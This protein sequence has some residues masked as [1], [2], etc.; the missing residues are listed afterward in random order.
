MTV[1][2]AL[3]VPRMP[4]PLLCPDASEGYRALA[5][6]YAEAR[7]RIEAVQPDLI[8]LYSA[9]W[10]SILGHQVQADPAPEWVHVDQDFHALGSIPYKLR[11][12]PGFADAMTEAGQARGL[13]VRTVSY[14]GFPIDT[15]T[16]TALKLLNPDNRFPASVVSCNIY[17][18]RAET[19]VLGK[20]A[21]DAIR[22]QNRRVVAIA[23]T[24]ISHRLHSV[25]VPPDQD[26]FA[27]L[28][29]DEWTRKLLEILDEGRLEDVSQLARTFTAQAHA[30]SKLKGIWWLASCA[31]AHNRYSGEVL[32]YAPVQG[33]G[34]AVV[35]LKPDA[36][37]VANL[38]F[39]EDDVDVYRGDR[40]V[41][42]PAGETASTAGTPAPSAPRRSE[43]TPV[44]AKSPARRGTGRVDVAA[45]RAPKPVGAYPHARRV[46]DLL[47]L[48]GVGPRQA[49]TDAIPGGPIR[50]ADGVAQEYDIE[51]QTR[52]VID[53][54]RRILEAAGSSLDRVLDVTTFLVDMDRDFK[55]Y[56]R[57]YAELLGG[58][59]PT[60]TTLAIRALP[61]PIAIELKV[62]AA[63]GD[64]DLASLTGVMGG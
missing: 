25:P 22:A 6:A 55:G 15:G 63:A 2:L 37:A 60:R 20:A 18:D 58:I 64:A 23:V 45:D 39:D 44:A 54:V 35:S 14:K 38:E 56:N 24:N 9:G 30:D 62:V 31:G 5:D 43:A 12:D 10:N 53:N 17:A 32:A 46:G 34:C 52:A 11:M 61:T 21:A 13:R 26:R 49:G 8:V 48:S 28:K 50:N 19:V 42:A 7:R 51:A 3:I 40:N 59:G 41:L 1:E 33:A 16:V 36:L 57:V 47:Y 27:S 29:D 4:H